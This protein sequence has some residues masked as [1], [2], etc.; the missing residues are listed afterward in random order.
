MVLQ[1]F[2]GELIVPGDAAYEQARA[3]Y[4]YTGSPAVV[5]RPKTAADVVTA[6]RYARTN[7]LAISVRSGGHSVAG[8]STNTGGLVIDMSAMNS[9]D[10]IDAS[11]HLVRIGSG[12]RWK[13]VAD[14][15]EVHGLA[16]S[17]GDSASVGVGGLALGGGVGWMV[18]KYGLTI[19]S[20][21]AAEIITAD[22]RILRAGTDEHQDLFWAIRGGGGNFG[23]ITHFEF[24][25]HP[26]GHVYAGMI[27]YAL[28]DVPALIAGWRDY[29]RT[30][31]EDLTVIFLLLPSMMG[32]PPSAIAW[33]C[34][35]GDGD[36]DAMASI[37]PLLHIGTVVQNTVAKKK[38]SEVLEEPHPPDG[39]KIIIKNCFVEALSD[40][41]IA[42]VAAHYGKKTSP[43][44][45]IRY[46][47]GAM[48]RVPA[49]ATAFAHRTSEALLVPAIFMP[50]EASED[51]IESALTPW[52]AVAPYASGAYI[53]FFSTATGEEVA[54]CYP[55]STLD[56]LSGIKREFDPENVFNQNFNVTPA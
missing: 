10:V 5:L 12:A 18:R 45:Q 24:A 56:R 17:S 19:D 11:K 2:S 22:G 3:T 39:M 53:N 51:E 8:H 15:L 44:L 35:A 36:A 1:D 7:S 29:M 9:V 41:L 30:A 47:G 32:N 4:I 34:Y 26:I 16:L 23:V 54:A 55:H 20:M 43:A 46:V 50:K 27:I 52:R 38:Y 13:N 21:V 48:K 42:E 14:A 37:D 28:E 33:C 40:T 49:H 31:T 25:A 6:I